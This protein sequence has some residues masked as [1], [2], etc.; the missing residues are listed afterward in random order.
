[1]IRHAFVLLL[2]FSLLTH[3]NAAEPTGFVSVKGKKVV[4]PDGSPFALRGI[5]LGNWLVPEGYMFRFDTASSPRLVQKVIVELIGPDAA[6]EFW[7]RFQDNYISRDD[8]QF[9]KQ[10]GFNSVRVPF[11]CR[12]FTPEDQPG[13]WSGR[14]F[15]LL[16]RVI[17][18]C[19][20]AGLRVVLDLH[21]APGGQTGDNI[22]D[23]WGYP[24]LFESQES[25]ERTVTLWRKIAEHYKSEPVVA[26]YDLL[27][28]PIAH[29]FD[30]KKLNPRLEPLYQRIVKAIREVDSNH[31]VFL[32]GAQWASKFD[33]FGSP[34]DSKLVYS[35]HKYWTDPTP[36]VIQDYLD[37]S[38]KYNVPLYMGESGENNDEWIRKFRETL[39]QN[40]ISWCFWPYKK[41]D[42]ASCVASIEKPPHFDE[43]IAYANKPR[44]TFEQVRRARDAAPEAAKALDVFLENCRVKNCRVNSGYLR[45][46]G[47]KAP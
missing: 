18:W 12:S 8:I 4:G 22:D 24:W 16:D 36:Q 6:R 35:F 39:E 38:R 33:V 42:A 13:V 15:E 44:D 2:S 19:R 47:M 9:L 26:G 30:V 1:M 25:Q 34:F 45:A 21:C 43:V 31:L 5:N 10:A 28:E 41:M 40:E 7:T 20:E 32:E 37:F 11:N 3:L 23:S 14:G 46:L 27:N 29:H 17:G